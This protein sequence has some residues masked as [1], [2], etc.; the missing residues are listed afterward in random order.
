MRFFVTA[1][2]LLCCVSTAI[3]QEVETIDCATT[4]AWSLTDFAGGVPAGATLSTNEG[5]LALQYPRGTLSPL[6]HAVSLTE[7]REIRLTLH[8]AKDVTIALG[9]SDRDGAAFH[10]SF[11]LKAGEWTPIAAKARDFRLNDDSPVRKTALDTKRLGTGYVI[12]DAGAFLGAEGENTLLID[13][14]EIDRRTLARETGDWIVAAKSEVS[15]SVVRE[16]DLVV[17]KGAH[18]KITAPRFALRGNVTVENAVLEF[19]GGTVHFPQRFNHELKITVSGK[20]RLIFRHVFFVTHYPISLDLR[21]AAVLEIDDSEFQGGLTCDSQTTCKI[22]LHRALTPGEFILW[23][24]TE[25]SV[26]DSDFVILW[27]GLGENLKGKFSVPSGE[28]VDD[29]ISGHGHQARVRNSTRMLF[30]VIS[31]AGSDGTIEETEIYSAGLYFASDSR[32]ALKDLHNT[33]VVKDFR[34]ESDD[35]KLRFRNAKVAAWNFYANERA[36]LTVERCTFGEALA[37]GDGRMEIRNSACDGTGGYVGTEGRSEI[38]LVR[39][40]IACLVIARDESTLILEDCEISG[41][42]RATG[43]GTVRLVRCKT[44]GPI[45]TD[46]EGRVLRE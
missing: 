25:I 4:E 39:C 22:R 2:S 1:I 8:S 6:V 3:A 40:K 9:F 46:G 35:R 33:K 19:S 13:K 7:F 43:K 34:L 41:A 36:R 21:D 27:F 38:R 12:L 16:G 15:E 14:V 44:S 11:D 26:T 24:G 29:W 30:C 37:F 31:N 10:F 28:K 23:P 42:V 32:V 20:S 18:L 45:E 17:K 5:K